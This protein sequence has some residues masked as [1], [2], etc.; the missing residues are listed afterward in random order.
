MYFYKDRKSITYSNLTLRP[1]LL[2]CELCG[3]KELYRQPF[4]KRG[5]KTPK[6]KLVFC[7]KHETDNYHVFREFLP[8]KKNIRKKDQ[9]GNSTG[10]LI[11]DSTFTGF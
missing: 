6:A 10:V 8:W 1:L 2:L 4:G 5:I 9:N 11:S 3:Y 7:L